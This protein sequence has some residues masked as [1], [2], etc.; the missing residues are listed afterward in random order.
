MHVVNGSLKRFADTKVLMGV[1]LIAVFVFP[2]PAVHVTR[3]YAATPAPI[4]NLLPSAGFSEGWVTEGKRETFGPE[5]LYQHIDGEAELFM[6]YGFEALAFSLYASAKDLNTALAVDIYRMR[7][8]L[9]AY[10]I[11]SNYRNPDAEA[12]KVGSEAFVGDTQ[13]MFYQDRYFVEIT[14]SGTSTPDRKAFEA[15]AQAIAGKLPSPAVKPKEITLLNAPQIAARTEKYVA[16][17]VLGYAFFKRG[18]TAEASVDGKTAKAF[19]ILNGSPADARLAIDGYTA[20]LRKAGIE[21]K[22]TEEKGAVTI[23]AKDPLYKALA[24]RQAGIYLF[25]VINAEAPEKGLPLLEV[26]TAKR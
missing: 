26:L 12:V 5:N 8:P 14:A 13:L 2:S 4:T 17:S 16:E 1:L 23:L 22:I 7:S 21:P 19:V 6:P 20:Y 25:G 9:D 18:L 15:A 11:Y 3:A 10:G 24:L